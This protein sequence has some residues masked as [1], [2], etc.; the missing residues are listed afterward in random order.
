M[1]EPS[2]DAAAPRNEP[3]QALASFG[4]K[5]D[6]A[7][8][9][10]R[11]IR[12][13]LPIYHD[14]LGGMLAM[15]GDN[16][17][18]GYRA[19]QLRYANGNRVELMEPLEGS[20]FFD[21]FFERNNLGGL[22]HVTFKVDDIE[23]VVE[24]MRAMGYSLTGLFLQDASWLEV[25]LHPREAFGTLIQLAQGDGSYEDEGD[26][27]LEDVLAGHGTRGNGAPSP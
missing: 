25:F 24:A 14:L 16:I 9:A 11:R 13:L 6:H 10:S 27:T 15:G 5:F 3:I 18:V 4:A 12:D 19:L 21:T 2:S 17:R 22:H 26:M 23:L 8:V 20:H 1:Q 7:A